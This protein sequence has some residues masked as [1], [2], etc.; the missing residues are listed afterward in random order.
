MTPD[1]P[2][3]AEEGSSKKKSDSISTVE[4][5]KDKMHTP[6]AKS[7]SKKVIVIS[8]WICYFLWK[9]FIDIQTY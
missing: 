4:S 2:T 8:P 3:R 5:K 9:M 6:S 7:K 1:S